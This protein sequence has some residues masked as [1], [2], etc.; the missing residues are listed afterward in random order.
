[1]QTHH[2][3]E[4]TRI[5]LD[6]E[7]IPG[8]KATQQMWDDIAGDELEVSSSYNAVAECVAHILEKDYFD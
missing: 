4:I 3:A 1:M 5:D 6:F 2:Q 7:T 8:W